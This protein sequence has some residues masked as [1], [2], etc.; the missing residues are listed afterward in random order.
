[1]NRI[2]GGK[3]Q[4]STDNAQLN[5]QE[6]G[7][8]KKSSVVGGRR[9]QR[10]KPQGTKSRIAEA[11]DANLPEKGSQSNGGQK[12]KKN[13]QIK[14]VRFVNPL[15]TIE[16]K[17]GDEPTKERDQ[18][19]NDGQ[20]KSDN[21][22]KVDDIKQ[23]DQ[24]RQTDK[25]QK[26]DKHNTIDEPTKELEQQANDEPE[27]EDEQETA[28]NRRRL[29]EDETLLAEYAA[30]E[31]LW[32]DEQRDQLGLARQL[33]L[34]EH[35][36]WSQN[37]E[38][39]PRLAPWAE[40][41]TCHPDSGRWMERAR[42]LESGSLSEGARHMVS[43]SAPA[44]GRLIKVRKPAE[45]VGLTEHSRRIAQARQ[46]EQ[47]LRQQDEPD[48]EKACACFA[49][50]SSEKAADLTALRRRLHQNQE[51]LTVF[52]WSHIVPLSDSHR[53]SPPDLVHDNP[54]DFVL[55]CQKM[56]RHQ[57]SSEPVM[58]HLLKMAVQNRNLPAL[59]K[60]LQGLRLAKTM[61]WLKS[62]D[63]NGP[64][65]QALLRDTLLYRP[66][67][68]PWLRLVLAAGVLDLDAGQPTL[69]GHLAF[70]GSD[71]SAMAMLLEAGANPNRGGTTGGTPLH[72][73]IEAAGQR[74]QDS[75]LQMDKLQL[76]LAQPGIDPQRQLRHNGVLGGSA[77][78]LAAVLGV[79]P[80]VE[81]L[82]AH[83]STAPDCLAAMEYGGFAMPKGSPLAAAALAFLSETTD[84]KEAD[85]LEKIICRLAAAGAR[86]QLTAPGGEL[87][88]CTEDISRLE[89]L[90]AQ[91]GIETPSEDRIARLRAALAASPG[92]PPKTDPTR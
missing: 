68:Q 49:R 83:P 14:P 53:R 45:T 82:L 15:E 11:S 50:H 28:D 34:A 59:F 52:S 75:R 26:A 10:I 60:M 5:V 78:H 92:Q 4:G 64:I 17:R 8:S 80:A 44:Q 86:L 73:C 66:A 58:V 69:L 6:D 70:A 25:P 79:V 22:Q 38:L 23:A 67:D 42:F 87:E 43:V 21:P 37:R 39:S 81:Q 35:I 12:K 61:G 36:V 89:Q 29:A 16:E 40:D 19:K 72:A 32:Q 30:L 85:Q 57:G 56:R 1:M 91:T 46:K 33:M 63:L 74:L 2:G 31:K 84:A 13:R 3:R 24:S 48:L 71:T 88:D 90:C 41:G 9:S 47:A 20:K 18:P 7:N 77:L 55:K 62:A 65:G 54:L 76:L 51:K 27:T